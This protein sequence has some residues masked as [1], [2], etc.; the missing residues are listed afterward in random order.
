MTTISPNRKR[1]GTFG[2]GVAAGV[3]ILCILLA[4]VLRSQLSSLFWRVA[5][6][7][8][9]LRNSLGSTEVS[10]LQGELA[11]T[12]AALADRNSLYAQNLQLKQLLGRSVVNHT[13]LA[14][15]LERP[16]EIPYDTLMIDIGKQNGVAVGNLVFAGGNTVVGTVSEVYDTTARVTLLSAP[17]ESYDAL[18]GGS[19]P[20]TLVGQGVGSMSGEVPANTT[21]TVGEPITLP[22]ML[23]A[24]AG[25]V[26]YI[27]QESDLSFI[28]LYVQL[29]VDLFSLQYVEVQTSQ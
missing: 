23:S 18:L 12:T 28:T 25:S 2:T 19:V 27:Q 15:V 29:P 7:I 9:S 8:L 20:I 22:G 14:A 4:V 13:V 11:S 6:P 1:R 10:V 3:V 21:V 5:A 17:G 24:F 26:S 16:P